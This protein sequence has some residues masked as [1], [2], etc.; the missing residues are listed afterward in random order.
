MLDLNQVGSVSSIAGL[1]VTLYEWL[2]VQRKA[3]AEA[4]EGAVDDTINSYLEWL[5]RQ[6][7]SAVLLE[8]TASQEKLGEVGDYRGGADGIAGPGTVTAIR[9]Y[10]ESLQG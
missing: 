1:A 3:R 10:A 4:T 8:L 5:R 7:H 2:T 6:D 9:E